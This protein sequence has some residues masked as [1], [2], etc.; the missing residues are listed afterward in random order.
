MNCPICENQTESKW[1]YCPSCGIKINDFNIDEGYSI[2]RI[3]DEWE[4]KD[5]Q[6]FHK[7]FKSLQHLGTAPYKKTKPTRE[8]MGDFVGIHFS[9]MA[10]VSLL[11]TQ[12]Q[13][14]EQ[15]EGIY[16][17]MGYYSANTGL[18]TIKLSK[19]VETLSKI[20]LT[21]KI[22]NDK[23][24][25]NALLEGWEKSHE[26]IL[27]VDNIDEKGII[28]VIVEEDSTDHLPYPKLKNIVDLNILLGNF[29]AILG[30][31]LWI[32]EQKANGQKRYV[33]HRD[34]DN[35]KKQ[36]TKPLKKEEYEKVLEHIIEKIIK[37]EPSGRTRLKDLV[38][39][40]GEQ[41]ATYFILKSSEGH[42]I[43]EKYAGMTCGK[44]FIEKT[45]A[46]TEA[47]ALELIQKIFQQ[48]LIGELRIKLK[49]AEK[50]SLELTESV[51]SSGV[52][53]IGLP[54]DTFLVGIIEGA[55]TQATGK[56]YIAK[57]TK[58]QAM[59]HSHCE[60]AVKIC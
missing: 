17:L 31:K 59:G 16:R 34:K 37:N 43:V 2:K 11:Y 45:G 25:N 3:Q 49:T 42:R 56:R 23:R 27:K 44:K 30:R 20:G 24:V 7:K 46:E 50:I 32:E 13:L 18:K 47:H 39:I 5:G 4:A 52:D 33:I 6:E 57:E 21:E 35:S 19:F 38:H 14:Q 22:L 36:K 9:N 1:V 15:I 51:Y 28:S 26:A 60:I 40:S 55:L 12:P 8:K 41:S 53:N 54:L 29:E 10:L 58:C 48:Q